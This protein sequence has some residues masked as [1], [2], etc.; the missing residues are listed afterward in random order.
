VDI[1]ANDALQER[2]LSEQFSSFSSQSPKIKYLLNTIR[3]VKS[4]RIGELFSAYRDILWDDGRH[5]YNVSSFIGEIDEILLGERFSAFD[6]ATLD[7]LIG[8][9]RQRGNSNATINRKMAALSKLLRKAYKMGDIHSLPEFRRQKERAG[10]IRFLERDEEARLF[11][12]IRGRSEDAWRLAVF[13]VDTGCRLGEALGLIWNDI[14]EHRVSFWIT[15]SGRSRTIPLTDRAREAVAYSDEGGR[16]PKG[17]FAMLT[18]P[19][20]RAIWNEAKME[21]GLGADTQVVPHILRHTCA[22]RLVQGGIDIRRVQMWLGHQTLQ[23]TMR[24]AHLAANDLDGCV[25]V[26]EARPAPAAGKA[27]EPKPE[28]DAAP[29]PRAKRG[30]TDPAAGKRAAK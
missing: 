14:Q 4:Y 24:Y 19:Q 28:S 16:R 1:M 27:G 29:K 15:K 20:F 13:L 18:Q 26:L 21:V 30:K 2:G 12:A 17:P 9:L 22:S 10:R 5:K 7:N 3:E 23:M 6:Q 11:A 8:T 25:M